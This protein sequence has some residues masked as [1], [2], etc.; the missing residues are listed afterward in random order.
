[1]Y[2]EVPDSTPTQ[3]IISIDTAEFPLCQVISDD[4]CT[5]FVGNETRD[6]VY[7]GCRLGQESETCRR[8]RCILRCGIFAIGG[9]VDIS[10]TFMT[11]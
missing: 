9:S 3:I 2:I 6:T 5:T 7:W 10:A 1:M 4:G 8:R 11:G